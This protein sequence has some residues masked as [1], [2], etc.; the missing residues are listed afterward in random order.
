MIRKFKCI[1]CGKKFD[2]DDKDTIVCPKCHS[3]NVKPVKPDF[4]KPIGLAV[5]L[6]VSVGAGMFVT[7]QC[8]SQ[9]VLDPT[10]VSCCSD[11]DTCRCNPCRCDSIPPDPFISD[12]VIDIQLNK[13]DYDKATKSYSLSV[14]AENLPEGGNVLYELCQE[15]DPK[16]N[17]KKVVMTSNDGVFKNVPAS[18]NECN[19]YFVVVTVSGDDGQVISSKDR[20]FEGFVEVMH[21]TSRITKDQ[22]Q[23]MIKRHDAALQGGNHNISNNVMILVKGSGLKPETFQ[24]VYNNLEFDVWRSVTVLSVDYDSEN[25]VNKVVLSVVPG[26]NN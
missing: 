3:D 1:A 24:D 26:E 5:V 15:Y 21:V 13:L 17:I 7:K 12:D 4:L 25:R 22:L 20:E 8:K 10:P 23:G 14:T 2:A 11:C 19:T 9:D 18:K 6:L 16:N